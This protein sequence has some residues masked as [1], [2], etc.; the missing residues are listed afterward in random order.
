MRMLINLVGLLLVLAIVAWLVKGS[1]TSANRVL[2]ASPGHSAS[3]P[4]TPQ[5]VQQQYKQ[6]LEE[7]LKVRPMPADE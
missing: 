2:P 3:Q 7:A 1:F 4:S 5:Q 6:A